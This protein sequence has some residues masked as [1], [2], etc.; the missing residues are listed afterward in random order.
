LDFLE[1][2]ADAARQWK[3]NA[4][5]PALIASIVFHRT[6]KHIDIAKQDAAI[7]NL[8]SISG[9]SVFQGTQQATYASTKAALN[10]LTLY[11][12]S[13]Y[14][15]YNVRV[16]GLSPNSFPGIVSTEVVVK[17]AMKILESNDTGRIYDLGIDK[18]R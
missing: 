10:M 17:A 13:E 2:E 9:K 3:L 15:A 4:L 8:S 16:N 5:A 12:A 1:F 18:H 11:M 6:W 7:L 14:R